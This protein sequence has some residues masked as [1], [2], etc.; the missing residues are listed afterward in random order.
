MA[1]DLLVP[2]PWNVA[3]A[4]QTRGTMRRR[5]RERLNDAYLA[6]LLAEWRE[7][8]GEYSRADRMAAERGINRSTLTRQLTEARRRSASA[9]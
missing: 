7:R 5:R 3:N 4:V 6:L 9:H 1:E 8:E 2:A